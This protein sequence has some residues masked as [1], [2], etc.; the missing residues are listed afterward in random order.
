MNSSGENSRKRKD[1][2]DKS[3]RGE[4]RKFDQISSQMRE[5]LIRQCAE[6]VIAHAAGNG[7]GSRRGF[8]K[9]LVDE[10]FRRAPSME[11]SRDDINNKVRIIRGQREEEEQREVSPA[12][13][14]HII[15]DP[16][17]STRQRPACAGEVQA[18]KGRSENAQ[19]GGRSQGL[20]E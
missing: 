7:G 2:S 14:F 8:V 6:Q 15:R 9:G 11:I 20:V 17:L 13:P 19:H 3:K 10:Y 18:F 12:I 16:S 4:Y 5:T 1:D